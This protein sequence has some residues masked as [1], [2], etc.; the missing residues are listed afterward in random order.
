M[1]PIHFELNSP[2]IEI[3]HRFIIALE[4]VWLLHK[5]IFLNV[6]S[7]IWTY[8]FSRLVDGFYRKT[9]SELHFRAELR[10]P[11][12][13]NSEYVQSSVLG[14]AIKYNNGLAANLSS[15]RM[16]NVKIYPKVE[17]VLASLLERMLNKIGSLLHT[18][19]PGRFPSTSSFLL[20]NTLLRLFTS[21]ICTGVSV[22]MHYYT[23]SYLFEA[24]LCEI[25]EV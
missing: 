10:F 14:I 5:C 2:I 11:I 9:S 24:G 7:M 18:N 23:R 4:K 21:A 3:F 22:Q 17:S 6:W 16:V 15:R 1:P 8:H 20:F 13:C 25:R 12:G 19:V